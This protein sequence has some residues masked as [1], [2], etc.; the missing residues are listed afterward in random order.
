MA[1]SASNATLSQINIFPVKS[2]RGISLSSAWV[3]KQGISFDRRYMLADINGKMV[4]ART[5]PKLVKVNAVLSESGMIFSYQ[6]CEPL[7]LNRSEFDLE[8]VNTEVWSDRFV[9]YSTTIEANRWFSQVVGK[10]VQLLYTG[11]VSNRVREKLGH[12]VSFADG[13]PLLV[14]SEASLLALNQRCQEAQTMDQFRP[15]LVVSGNEAFVEDSWKKIRIGDVEFDVRKPCERCILTTVDTQTGDFKAS[16]EPLKTLSQFRANEKGQIYFGQNLVALNE[17]RIEQ[18]DAIEVL[19]YQDKAHYE[20][21]TNESL[22]LTCV[23]VEEIAREFVTYWFEPTHG[24]L[25]NFLAGQYLPVEVV[26]EAE[27][28]VR[29]YSLSSSPTRLGRYAISVKRVDGGKVSNHLLDNLQVGDV[30]SAET[31]QGS[32]HLQ[33]DSSHPLLLLSAGSGI[34]PMIS[35]LRYLADNDQLSDVVFYHQCSTIADLPFKQELDDLHKRFPG[36][37]LIL[38]LSQAHTEW[39]GT[40]GRLTLSHLKQIPQL[41]SRQAFVCGPDAFMK[42]AKN[43]LIKLGLPESYYHQESFGVQVGE[44]K[45]EKKALTISLDGAR[46]IGDNVSLLLLQMENQ[47]LS[48]ANSCRAGLCGA[49]MLTLTSG[50][51]EQ[52]NVPALTESERAQGKILACCCVPKTDI[53]LSR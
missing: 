3:E 51:V 20:D 18:G 24:V 8:P 40:K 14:I 27:S 36:L 37:Q 15:N 28:Y 7:L 11:A 6:N 38:S 16:K 19:E 32:F 13:Y 2:I 22:R 45:A 50:E 10:P 48:I 33:H 4:T 47:N 1:G 43:L 9:A 49:C 17:G 5:I 12:S 34:T 42:K 25:P 21:N 29:Y 52:E 35:M 53:E 39:E 31:P 30:L 46:F 41:A 44:I 26:V 23:E